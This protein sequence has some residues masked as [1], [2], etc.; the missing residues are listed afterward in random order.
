MSFASPC[1][2]PL[3]PGYLS[4]IAAG[5]AL[6][7]EARGEP[8]RPRESTLITIL[9]FA[10]GFASVFTALGV[11]AGTLV[12]LLRGPT[13]RVAAAGVVVA[14]GLVMMAF[15]TGRGARF[16]LRER[17]PFLARLRPGGVAA[18]P[19]GMAFAAGWTPCI[20][21]VLAAILTLAA[22]TGGVRAAMLLFIYSLG[23]GVPF[24]L[25]GLGADRFVR[26]MRVIQRY[27]ARIVGAAG[28]IL[29]W[30]VC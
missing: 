17:R 20:G 4:F 6:D 15:A 28:S 23:L 1:V 3:V 10:L 18:V 27:H 22:S 26:H 14:V 21:P 24:V 12:P 13:G 25:I 5:S 30:S 19:L 11:A 8:G 2:L 29:S 16:L 9:L 7:T